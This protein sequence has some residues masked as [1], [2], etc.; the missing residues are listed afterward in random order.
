VIY[1]KYIFSGEI[2]DYISVISFK[3][4]TKI[5]AIPSSTVPIFDVRCQ[6]F[7]TS[8][9]EKA[10]LKIMMI[11]AMSRMREAMIRPA[12]DLT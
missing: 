9:E 3:F 1:I 11:A 4:E 7:R 12:V 6:N 8:T 2:R 5:P 10:L